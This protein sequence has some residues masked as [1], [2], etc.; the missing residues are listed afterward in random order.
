MTF[1][2]SIGR[3]NQ[4]RFSSKNK[5]KR[6]MSPLSFKATQTKH[7]RQP[8]HGYS[9]QINPDYVTLLR[10]TEVCVLSQETVG[11]LSGLPGSP[12]TTVSLR[13]LMLIPALSA[14]MAVLTQGLCPSHLQHA[15][16]FSSL[17]RM[18]RKSHR[19]SPEISCGDLNKLF[20]QLCQIFCSYRNI[21]I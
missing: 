17:S 13:K 9:F 6:R 3:K 20:Y 15:S 8:V 12:N 16:C 1:R 14:H 19:N 5:C 18:S 2:R 7:T 21:M 11:L 4:K 10:N